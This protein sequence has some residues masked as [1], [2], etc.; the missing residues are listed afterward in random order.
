MRLTCD[1]PARD[2]WHVVGLGQHALPF[3]LLLPVR[4]SISSWGNAQPCLSC[5]RR[6]WCLVGLGK[7]VSEKH[8]SPLER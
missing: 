6:L 7:K 1:E 5:P 8:A 3:F 2:A 4:T